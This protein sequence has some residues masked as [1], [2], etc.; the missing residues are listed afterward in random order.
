[1][2]DKE[3]LSQDEVDA[4]MEGVDN[5]AIEQG[6]TTEQSEAKVLDFATQERIVRSQ[7]PVL[8]R[9]HERFAKKL[10]TSLYDLISREAEIELDD[11]KNLKYSEYIKSLE[12]PC[13]INLLRMSPMR[14]KSMI[15]LDR[16]LIYLIVDNYFGGYGA[17]FD[18]NTEVDEFTPTELQINNVL[19]DILMHDLQEAWS[20]IMKVD[21]TKVGYEMNP[22]LTNIVSANEVLLLSEF[23]VTINEFSGKMYI[24][25][26][27]SMLEPVREQ[28]DLGAARTDDDIDPHWVAALQK[29]LFDAKVSL[30]AFFPETEATLGDIQKLQ[31]GD[32]IPIELPDHI[33]AYIN[34]IPRFVA[35]Y[36]LSRDKY[37]LKIQHK[38]EL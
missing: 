31:V 9:I 12:A 11:L 23:K 20:P 24:V 25:L 8:Q 7:F 2:T 5:G 29:E 33:T 14:G 22:Q 16:E 37:S 19:I 30:Q 27:Y 13:S 4:L 18:K 26:P 38:I 3:V 6:A 15:A 34:G 32:I 28:L 1:M 10:A 36:G 17:G 21:M 35:K